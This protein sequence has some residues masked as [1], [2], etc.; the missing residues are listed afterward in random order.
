MA[1][2]KLKDSGGVK[3]TRQRPQP[4]A[5]QLFVWSRGDVERQAGGWK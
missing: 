2:G 3:E 4:N 1:G 5:L